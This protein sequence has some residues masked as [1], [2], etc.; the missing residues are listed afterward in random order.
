MNRNAPDDQ[1][2][3]DGSYGPMTEARIKKAPAEGFG[4]GALC[5]DAKRL[6]GPIITLGGELE[7][8]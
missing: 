2:T 7:S 5:D 8:D 1:I 6:P 4:I 3:E